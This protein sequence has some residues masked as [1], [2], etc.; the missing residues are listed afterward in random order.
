M[1]TRNISLIISLFALTACGS[2]GFLEEE[3]RIIDEAINIVVD[4]LS[5]KEV[6]TEYI[7]TRADVVGQDIIIDGEQLAST[8][9]DEFGIEIFE[10]PEGMDRDDLVGELRDSNRF[11][12]VEDAE[13]FQLDMEDR[14]FDVMEASSIEFISGEA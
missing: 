5:A 7:V 9:I 1:T 4:K 8:T 14:I 13:D 10:I 11:E 12:Y 3:A 2:E 6:S